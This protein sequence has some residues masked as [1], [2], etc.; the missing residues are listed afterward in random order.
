M[1]MGIVE[2]GDDRSPVS[3]N[4][5]CH[6]AAQ[7]KDLL[8]C[9]GGADCSG[10]NGNSF[11]KGWHAVCRNL[12]VV[13]Y[14]VNCHKFLLVAK[15]RCSEGKGS[16]ALHKHYL[17]ASSAVGITYSGKFVAGAP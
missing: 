8:V 17:C 9:T 11:D 10:G 15:R 13:K 1:H 2:T 5:C 12:R 14:C 6:W 4:D 16:P 3:I 7:P